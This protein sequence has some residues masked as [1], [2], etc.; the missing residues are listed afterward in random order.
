[1]YIC[2]YSLARVSV[3]RVNV[4]CGICTRILYTH[5]LAVTTSKRMSLAR[6][7]VVMSVGWL[8]VGS[9]VSLPS[10]RWATVDRPR[11]LILINMP[12]IAPAALDVRFRRGYTGHERVTALLYQLKYVC[13]LKPLNIRLVVMVRAT[14]A[15]AGSCAAQSTGRCTSQVELVELAGCTPLCGSYCTCVEGK[16]MNSYVHRNIAPH[17]TGKEDVLFAHADMWLNIDR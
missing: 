2:V 10:R 14:P 5:L 12:R 7:M 13:A 11:L 4:R 15:T 16:Y 9:N 17:L 6:M 3:S 8:P 1:M